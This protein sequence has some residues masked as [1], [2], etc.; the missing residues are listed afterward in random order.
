MDTFLCRNNHRLV[1][2]L[3]IYDIKTSM[4]IRIWYENE[5]DS[6]NTK[7]SIQMIL[8]LFNIIFYIF[9]LIQFLF[10]F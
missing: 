2:A 10:Y 7:V 3:V 9:F 5:W 6:F 4:I 1:S 8:N